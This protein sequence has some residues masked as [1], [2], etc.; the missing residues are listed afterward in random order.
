MGET[1]PTPQ[2]TGRHQRSFKN[3]LLDRHFQLKYTGYLMAI[4]F[5]LSASLG[6]ILFRT[7]GKLVEQ[8]ARS[9][10]QGTQ[11]VDLGKEVVGESRKVSA[12]VRMNIVK[13]PIYQ[14]DPDLLAAFNRDADD[15]DK[16]LDAQHAQ[17]EEQ[18]QALVTQAENLQRFH[19]IMLFSLAG[20]L[21]LLVVA[22]GMAGIFVT[23]KVA[24]PIFKMKRHLGEVA[25]GKYQVPWSLRKGDE[26]VEFF[27]AFRTM[28]V[29]LRADR[30]QN[31]ERLDEIRA[32][33]DE[34]AS[35]EAVQKI[36]SLKEDLNSAL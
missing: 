19:K 25:E 5:V 33:L 31:L 4:A 12:V 14:D 21:T 2:K 8:S 32:T 1:K 11:I 15:Q 22:I 26:L 36:D 13:D 35:K 6:F 16:K 27:E 10:S 9:A 24:G 29:A 28:V 3:L 20:I 23:H 18:R 34:G 7:S 17:L 30:E